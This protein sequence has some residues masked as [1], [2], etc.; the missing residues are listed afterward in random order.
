MKSKNT[1]IALLMLALIQAAEGNDSAEAQQPTVSEESA[2][3]F[4]SFIKDKTYLPVEYLAALKG[5][6]R[7]ILLKYNPQIESNSQLGPRRK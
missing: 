2:E 7:N 4:D 6:D 1:M 3:D 5:E